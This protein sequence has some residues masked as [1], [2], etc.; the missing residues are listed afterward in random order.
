MKGVKLKTM[1]LCQRC[2]P[3]WLASPSTWLCTS[4]QGRL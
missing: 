2:G 3:V 4:W 1:R